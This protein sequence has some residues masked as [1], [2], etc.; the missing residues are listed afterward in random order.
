[1]VASAEAGREPILDLIRDL[2]LD[3]LFA[4][5]PIVV[6]DAETVELRVRLLESGADVCFPPGI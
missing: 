4:S 2:R 5:L 3:P 6:V 1:M